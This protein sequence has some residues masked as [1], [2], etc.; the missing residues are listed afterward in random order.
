MTITALGS[1]AGYDRA[2]LFRLN[3]AAA[4]EHVLRFSFPHL[5]NRSRKAVDTVSLR[6]ATHARR[7]HS[8]AASPQW[9]G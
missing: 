2:T 5:I 6:T 3:S 4:F 7:R 9:T 1:G 8:K